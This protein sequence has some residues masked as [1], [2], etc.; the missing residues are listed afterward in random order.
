MKLWN[1]SI[2]TQ[3]QARRSLLTNNEWVYH[4]KSCFSHLHHHTD[5][6]HAQMHQKASCWCS[7]LTLM[8]SACCRGHGCRLG[9]MV[10]STQDAKTHHFSA[11]H[12]PRC[13]ALWS[14]ICQGPFSSSNWSL[15]CFSYHSCQQPIKAQHQPSISHAT[16][17]KPSGGFFI[18]QIKSTCSKSLFSWSWFHTWNSLVFIY[19]VLK[20]H[21]L[22]FISKEAIKVILLGGFTINHKVFQSHG[23]LV[24]VALN[25]GRPSVWWTLIN[26]GQEI[27]RE[28]FD[29]G[30]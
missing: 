20:N 2:T 14:R 9:T 10:P 25:Q 1:H 4:N 13:V 16:S 23:S 15:L 3:S 17:S 30:M 19:P 29:M 18:L 12:L 11:L 7:G 26:E 6:N 21:F 5:S 24:A 8:Y 22:C 28:A 27:C